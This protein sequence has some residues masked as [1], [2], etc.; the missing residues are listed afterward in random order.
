MSP[1]TTKKTRASKKTSR[2]ATRKPLP[3]NRTTITPLGKQRV[4]AVTKR[5]PVAVP[6]S[7][8]RGTE[9]PKPTDG[10]DAVLRAYARLAATLGKSPSIRELSKELDMS[11]K[12]AQQH[13]QQLTLKGYL[14][15]LKEL[16]VIGREMTPLAEKYLKQS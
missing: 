9:P 12:G 14:R 3:R 11:E 13:V 8:A 7:R 5:I 1:R 15:E 16:R 4:R 6:G 10:Q 2:R